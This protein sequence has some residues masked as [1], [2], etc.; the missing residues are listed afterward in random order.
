MAIAVGSF[1]RWNVLT[2]SPPPDVN[3]NVNSA[4]V[5]QSISV[6]DR[7]TQLRCMREGKYVGSYPQAIM[8][9]VRAPV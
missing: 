9:E 4:M 6:D 2:T 5:V 1:V 8:V 7:G 3:I